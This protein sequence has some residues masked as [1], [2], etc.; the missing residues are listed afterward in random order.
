MR[1]LLL[2]AAIACL[3]ISPAAADS[4]L[5]TSSLATTTTVAATNGGSFVLVEPGM[6]EVATTNPAGFTNLNIN[7]GGGLTLPGTLSCGTNSSATGK[8]AVAFG[9]NTKANG[10]AST[11]LGSGAIATGKNSVALGTGSIAAHQERPTQILAHGV[12]PVG[13]LT[14]VEFVLDRDGFTE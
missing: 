10:D 2:G 8:D 3:L 1:A 9:P 4:C 13:R 11:A 6:N 12:E 5:T 14:V 7:S